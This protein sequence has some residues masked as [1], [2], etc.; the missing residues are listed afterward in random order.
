MRGCH[1]LLRYSQLLL[2]LLLLFCTRRRGAVHNVLAISRTLAFVDVND[3]SFAFCSA[4]LFSAVDPP[5]PPPPP[6][7][8]KR[9][10]RFCNTFDG[11]RCRNCAS[12]A[13]SA[14][15]VFTP[16]PIHIYMFV[17]ARACVCV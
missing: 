3:F 12:Q 14:I 1:V 17:F 9:T 15:S 8:V 7:T 13:P 2:L 4:V 6:S 11:W 5:L 10:K 16:Y